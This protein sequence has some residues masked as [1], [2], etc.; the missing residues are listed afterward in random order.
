MRSDEPGAG[1][2]R[3]RYLALGD[4]FTIGTGIAADRAFPRVLAARWRDRGLEVALTDPA[5]NGYTTDDLI[6]DELPFL[7]RVRPTLVTLL[8]GAN[9]IV[10]GWDQARYRSRLARIH[11]AVRAGAPDAAVHALPQPDWSLSPAAAA[12]GE[13]GALARTIERANEIAR[14]E[15][16][17]GGARYLDIFPLMRAQAERRMLAPDGLHPSADAHVEWAAAIDGLL[18]HPSEGALPPSAH[19]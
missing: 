6:R 17:R 11:E 2:P 7:S 8:I 1:P 3:I 14:E 16:E 18:I 15:A 19:A 13:P 4:S 5:V 10:R 12:Y 9:D